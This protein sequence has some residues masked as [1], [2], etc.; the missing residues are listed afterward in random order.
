MHFAAM[1]EVNLQLVLTSLFQKQ[2]MNQIT[3]PRITTF[4]DE[5]LKKTARKN[6]TAA[7]NA[8]DRFSEV[9]RGV[10]EYD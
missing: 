5:T 10:C 3:Q 8:F 1:D 6:V 4:T 2:K 7:E 9:D